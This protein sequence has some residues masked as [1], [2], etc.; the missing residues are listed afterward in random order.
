MV[1]TIVCWIL[2]VSVSL[3]IGL[4]VIRHTDSGR[5]DDPIDRLCLSVWMG[6]LATGAVAL[7]LASWTALS[8]P[9]ATTAAAG[10]L[11]SL[12]VVRS[13]LPTIRLSRVAWLGV[14]LLMLA[15]G[16]DSSANVTAYDTG[17]YHYQLVR[18]MADAGLV[19]DMVLLH[20]RFGLVSSW[21]AASSLF[22]HGALQGRVATVFGGL[23]AFL[24]LLHA[25]SLFARTL[26]GRASDSSVFLLFAYCAILPAAYWWSFQASLSSDWPVWIVTVLVAWLMF[27]CAETGR[28]FWIPLCLAGLCLSLK[29]SVLPLALFACALLVM[30]VHGKRKWLAPLLVGSLALP[31]VTASFVTTGCFVFPSAQTCIGNH[32][33]RTASDLSAVILS[34]HRWGGPR[35]DGFADS[36]WVERW[37]SVPDQALTAILVLGSTAAFLVFRVD[38]KMPAAKWPFCLACGGALFVA[39]NA[40]SVRFGLG[41]FVI[42]PALLLTFLV[43]RLPTTLR[44]RIAAVTKGWQPYFGVALAAAMFVGTV[45]REKVY[46]P[47]FAKA[48]ADSSTT[49]WLDNRLILPSR[50]PSNDGDL[51]VMRNRRMFESIPLQFESL[52]VNDIN[53]TRPIG[54]DQ[55]WA[56]PIPCTSEEPP[57]GLQLRDPSRGIRGGFVLAPDEDVALSVVQ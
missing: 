47:L 9:I 42:P 46:A 2:I 14:I 26:K 39:W 11:L 7:S 6:L 37:L 16:Y 30:N 32:A 48:E 15:V 19:S 5:L 54:T 50:L 34:W 24:V 36:A 55:C 35:P 53:Y 45:A 31:M 1:A 43:S 22:D 10:G 27:R 23:A 12:W 49:T 4:W 17:L 41:Y 8:A 29:L 40:P 33:A 28:S 52:T 21:L 44:G 51:I 20:R 18:W 38:K 25:S 57:A 3:P 56:A 13:H